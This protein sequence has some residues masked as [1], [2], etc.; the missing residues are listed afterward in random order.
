[1]FLHV[2]SQILFYLFLVLF[3]LFP[4]LSRF[5]Q[6]T[7]Q[8][9]SHSHLNNDHFQRLFLYRIAPFWQAAMSSDNSCCLFYQENVC[10]VYPLESPHEGDSHE[11]PQ[12]P[13]Q[14]FREDRKGILIVSLITSWLGGMINL[15]FSSFSCLGQI[16]L[17][18]NDN[19]AIWVR[20]YLR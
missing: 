4:L 19:R 9:V 2:P 12:H 11:Y 10:C 1:M 13:I 16:C 3:W 5:S 20:L 8:S 18:Q 15:Q 6:S 7:N 14:Y 17:I